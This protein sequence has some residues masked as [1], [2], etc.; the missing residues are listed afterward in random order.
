MHT[1]NLI[2]TFYQKEK[3]CMWHK[4]RH[5]CCQNLMFIC[6]STKFVHLSGTDL[7]PI[8]HLPDTCWHLFC[9]YQAIVDTYSAPVD[10]YCAPARHLYRHFPDTYCVHLSR[11][12]RAPVVH[13]ARRMGDDPGTVSYQLGIFQVICLCRR[14]RKASYKVQHVE[15]SVM[16]ASVLSPLSLHL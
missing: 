10:T 12:C 7:I 11:T 2:W 14:R 9:T 5:I 15:S 13:M 1:W 4:T 3:D 8:V 6:V 16:S